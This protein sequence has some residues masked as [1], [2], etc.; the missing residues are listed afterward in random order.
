M[1]EQA[2]LN[3]LGAHASI[4][5]SLE[6]RRSEVVRVEDAGGGVF[7]CRFFFGVGVPDGP[8]EGT[9]VLNFPVR[10]TEKPTLSS[11]WEMYPNQSL[12]LGQYPVVSSGVYVW[13]GGTRPDNGSPFYDGCTMVFATMGV[14]DLAVTIHA[15]FEGLAIR[16]T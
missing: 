14:S 10:F 13:N 15:V 7:R 2:R 1:S 8:G 9:V 5:G 3:L 12:T 11:G 16:P 4:A 6:N